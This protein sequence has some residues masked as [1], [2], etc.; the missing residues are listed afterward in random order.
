MRAPRA[1][2]HTHTRE[3]GDLSPNDDQ[4][5]G[6]PPFEPPAD[7][8]SARADVLTRGYLAIEPMAIYERVR[9]PVLTAVQ[10]GAYGH[11]QI[12][13]ALGR[14]AADGRSVTVETL[15]IELR[16]APAARGQPRGR[17]RS[18]TASAF[19][20]AV[21]DHDPEPNPEPWRSS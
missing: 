9:H 21:T 12:A 16:G 5:T 1:P 7:P 11:D 6:P 15:R 14:L 17:G 2:A 4:T 19:L 18:G 13:D 10:S 8:D 3:G 20:A